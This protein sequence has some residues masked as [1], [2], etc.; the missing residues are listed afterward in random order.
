MNVTSNTIKGTRYL[1]RSIYNEYEYLYRKQYDTLYIK[2]YNTDIEVLY[3][4][5]CTSYK[6]IYYINLYMIQDTW[7][8]EYITK[9]IFVT[10]LYVRQ[11]IRVYYLYFVYQSPINPYNIKN[12]FGTL[13][14]QKVLPVWTLLYNSNITFNVYLYTSYLHII[15][16]IDLMHLYKKSLIL[17]IIIAIRYLIKCEMFHIKMI[18]NI[19]NCLFTLSENY[20]I[21]LDRWQVDHRPRRF[22]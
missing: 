17:L 4:C 11:N 18:K 15:Y 19:L 21:L 12:Y 3:R 1:A 16:R 20:D 2:H 13:S 14:V 8:T 9:S 22:K 6:S 10:V 7:Y 5:N